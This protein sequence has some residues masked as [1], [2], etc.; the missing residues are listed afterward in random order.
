MRCYAYQHLY[1]SRIGQR[2]GRLQRS[3]N[4]NY[5]A[6]VATRCVLT[7]P[8]LRF[9]HRSLIVL[10]DNVVPLNAAMPLLRCMC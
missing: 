2:L 4:W 1:S 3:A 8:F 9:W 7:A 6:A 10:N 5:V